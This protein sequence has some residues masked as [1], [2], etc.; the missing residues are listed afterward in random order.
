[1]ESGYQGHPRQVRNR[2][3]V[4]P[5]ELGPAID[6]GQCQ[7]RGYAAES[8]GSMS[9]P[10][11]GSNYVP[12]ERIQWVDL[13]HKH[14]PSPTSWLCDCYAFSEKEIDSCQG[15]DW[16]NSASHETGR[17]TQTP[18]ENRLCISCDQNSIENIELVLLNCPKYND[19]RS[20]ILPQCLR[21]PHDYIECL[22]S[23]F[24]SYEDTKELAVFISKAIDLRVKWLAI[25]IIWIY[26]LS[27]HHDTIELILLPRQ[28]FRIN[29]NSYNHWISTDLV[30]L[31][32]ES[33]DWNTMD[34]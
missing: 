10:T 15:E 20:D 30:S 27:S 25:I 21:T 12:V 7:T 2:G 31:R 34:I 28:V 23:M 8:I 3:R 18:E 24:S 26:M 1:M 5:C 13:K 29:I 9:T 19:I 33:S 16:Y 14:W 22:K 17:Y 11:G 32:Q 4:H 6:G